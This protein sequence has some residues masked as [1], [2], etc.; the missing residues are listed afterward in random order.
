MG[1]HIERETKVPQAT[2]DF[3]KA[4]IA[5]AQVV[6]FSKGGC[7]FCTKAEKAIKSTKQDYKL[8][9]L[10]G[11]SDMSSSRL[12]ERD[13][14]HASSSMASS[15]E[16]VTRLRPDAKMAILPRKLLRNKSVVLTL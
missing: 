13:P 10:N 16:A 3:V 2:M 15:M 9:E 14:S 12:L 4:E 7:P 6:M 8:I 11:R 1:T 5:S